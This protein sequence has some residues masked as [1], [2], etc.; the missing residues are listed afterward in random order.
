M[1]LASHFASGVL[2]RDSLKGERKAI[3]W[4]LIVLGAFVF[5]W[6]FDSTNV[7]H[8]LQ[9]MAWWQQAIIISWNFLWLGTICYRCR[10]RKHWGYILAGLIGWLIWDIEWLVPGLAGGA[11][12]IHQLKQ[13]SKIPGQVQLSFP[14]G[15]ILEF[16]WMAILTII[17]LPSLSKKRPQVM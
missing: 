4:P 2:L 8:I 6:L 15:C 5:H 12:W 13:F 7:A 1:W 10:R 9:Q 3:R 11:G 14:Q 17:S 16:C